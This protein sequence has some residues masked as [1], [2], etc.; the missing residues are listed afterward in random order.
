[1][2]TW[3]TEKEKET[4]TSLEFQT[5]DQKGLNTSNNYRSV[6]RRNSPGLNTLR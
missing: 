4:T 1:M 6:S 3:S 5:V 2:L